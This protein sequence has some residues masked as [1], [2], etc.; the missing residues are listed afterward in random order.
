VSPPTSSGDEIWLLSAV[1]ATGTSAE[2]ISQ[3]L[4]QDLAGARLEDPG[5]VLKQLYRKLN[6]DLYQQGL[7]DA[8]AS[9]VAL[10]AKG[11]YA[12]IAQTGDGQVF[13]MRAGRLNQVTRPAAVPTPIKGGKSNQSAA[14]PITPSSLL[15][16]KDR[17]DSRQPAIFELTLLP[18]DRVMICTG[19]VANAL[20]E[21]S[22]IAQLA[23]G[24][25]ERSLAVLNTAAGG[26]AVAT[27]AAARERQP[28]LIGEPART[29]IAPLI[30]AIAV[31]LIVIAAVVF[32]GVL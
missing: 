23:M 8:T 21:K 26:A 16:A 27:V 25:I 3:A 6:T 12:T 24:D 2:S 32:F 5:A 7:G 20:D 4:K 29:S 28:V 18:E 30:A 22:L 10:V 17:L 19:G 13:L 11:K 14:A 15:G 9:A 31:V 1:E